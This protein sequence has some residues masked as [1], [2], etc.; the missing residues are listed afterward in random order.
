MILDGRTFLANLKPVSILQT[1]RMNILRTVNAFKA[2]TDGVAL[3]SSALKS[4]VESSFAGVQAKIA[5]TIRSLYTRSSVTMLR[6]LLAL[7]LIV[8]VLGKGCCPPDTWEGFVGT[9]AGSVK[10]GVPHLTKGFLRYHLNSTLGMVEVEGDVIVDGWHT[11]IK[12]IKDFNKNI[13]Y[14]IVNGNCFQLTL[15][16]QVPNC[17]PDNA[18]LLLNTYFGSGSETMGVKV[19]RYMVEDIEVYSTVTSSGCIPVDDVATGTLS[20]TKAEFIEVVQI[21][22]FTVGVEDRSVFNIPSICDSPAFQN[23][24]SGHVP[25]LNKW[26]LY[27]FH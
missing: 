1:S 6:L 4:V 17:I 7:V 3:C 16:P 15:G 5:E 12:I 14:V 2:L 27:D 11:K 25:V 10:D 18:D 26:M 24:S 21:S 19:Y 8:K 20:H 23:I 13:E 22:N 9:M